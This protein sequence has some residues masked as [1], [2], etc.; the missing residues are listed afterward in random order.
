ML[1]ALSSA[2]LLLLAT[3][4]ASCATIM[5]PPE[6]FLVV[7]K[8][9]DFVKAI[10]PEE[11]KLWLRDF[12]DD[13]RGGLAFWRDALK[14]DLEDNRGYVIISEAEVKDAAGTPGHE[15]VLE[16]T[17]NGRA[18][19]ELLALFIY[20][21]AFADTVRVVEYVAEKQAFATEVGAVRA[22]LTKLKP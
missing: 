1:R 18:V 14:A 17:V 6:R 21:G 19:R 9:G 13:D 10:T 3:G 11:S 8:G 16:S 20:G 22:S 5:E 15:F 7:D 12:P 2:L 4:V